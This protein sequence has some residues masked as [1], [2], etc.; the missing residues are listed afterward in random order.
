MITM[1]RRRACL[2]LGA[3]LPAGMASAQTAE[4]PVQVVT[5]IYKASAGKNGKYEGPT[6]VQDKRMRGRYFS[7]KLASLFDRAQK[8]ERRTGDVIVDFDPITNSQDPSVI[9]LSIT[10]EKEDDK[11]A[12][13]AAKFRTTLQGRDTMTVRYDLI[14]EK[15][16]WRIDD[17]RGTVDKDAWSFRQILTQGIAETAKQPAQPKGRT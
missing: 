9:G 5:A 10:S 16:G 1:D 15:G 8:E 12:V 11:S 13:V 14:R 3:L 2:I 6:A 17:I 4:T 7:A